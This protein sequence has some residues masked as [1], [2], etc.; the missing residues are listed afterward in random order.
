VRAAF[1]ADTGSAP[2]LAFGWRVGVDLGRDW[3]RLAA[4]FSQQLPASKPLPEGGGAR[5]SL[6]AGTL[7]PCVASE[8]L[9]GCGI[10]KLGTLQ[11]RGEDIDYPASHATFYAA[12]GAR[13]EYTPPLTGQLRLLTQVEALR[14][15][16][17]VSLQVVGQ[18]VWHSPLVTV[19]AG[20]GLRLLFR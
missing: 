14:P 1:F 17:P 5:A 20:I 19:A 15:L 7:A 6:L 18:E 12:I 11:T 9:S 16:T 3:F 10:F 4:E 13:L 2:T 8:M